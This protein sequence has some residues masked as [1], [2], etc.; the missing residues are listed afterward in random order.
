MSA[1]QPLSKLWLWPW[2]WIWPGHLYFR[3]S[4]QGQTLLVQ[5]APAK[6]VHACC[7]CTSLTAGCKGSRSA[8]AS[9]Q[10]KNMWQFCNVCYLFTTSCKRLLPCPV[11][12]CKGFCRKTNHKDSTQAPSS[13]YFTCCFL[14]SVITC[15][16]FPWK[17]YNQ[18]FWRL[19]F[20]SWNKTVNLLL[21]LEVII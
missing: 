13:P 17:Q 6:P 1:I 11:L 19:D 8:G 21:V 10:R 15:L 4:Q 18:L 2:S 5:K 20:Y 7:R 3:G 14:A 12:S 16:C 9:L